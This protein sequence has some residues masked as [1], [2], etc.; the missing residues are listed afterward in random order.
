MQDCFIIDKTGTVGRMFVVTVGDMVSSGITGEFS[1]CLRKDTSL[2]LLL[3]LGSNKAN[4]FLTEHEAYSQDLNLIGNIRG[5]LAQKVYLK[6]IIFTRKK[7][8]REAVNK[9]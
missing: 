6:E 2:A 5:I 8:L 1:L 4:E 7:G 9:K 3:N